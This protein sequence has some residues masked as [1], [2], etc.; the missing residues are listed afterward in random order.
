MKVFHRKIRRPFY[1]IQLPRQEIRKWLP[2]DYGKAGSIAETHVV[3]VLKTQENIYKKSTRRTNRVHGNERGRDGLPF[4]QVSF[5]VANKVSSHLTHTFHRC[6]NNFNSA[7]FQ[8][9]WYLFCL[10]S[11]HEPKVSQHT[12]TLSWVKTNLS[13]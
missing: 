4:D 3:A 7:F 6:R 10:W 2:P 5:H 13:L 12:L 9:L 11:R 8:D 1:P